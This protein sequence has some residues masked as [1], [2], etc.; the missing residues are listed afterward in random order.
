MPDELLTANLGE[1][2]ARGFDGMKIILK[3]YYPIPCPLGLF[4]AFSITPMHGILN[5]FLSIFEMSR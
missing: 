1:R 4:R 5:F 3:L 2:K